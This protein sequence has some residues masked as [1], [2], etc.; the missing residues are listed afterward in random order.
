MRDI[1]FVVWSLGSVCLAVAMPLVAYALL[2]HEKLN[3]VSQHGRFGGL[4]AREQPNRPSG[5]LPAP[6]V[7][8]LQGQ[9]A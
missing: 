9:T 2:P 6:S 7:R 1:A 8:S 3:L 4:V 5:N